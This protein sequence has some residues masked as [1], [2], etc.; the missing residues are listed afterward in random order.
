MV[1]QHLV[2]LGATCR[3]THI[4]RDLIQVGLCDQLRV[5][6]LQLLRDVHLADEG[7]HSDTCSRPGLEPRLFWDVLMME[8]LEGLVLE[9]WQVV[10]VGGVLL[11]VTGL[12]LEGVLGVAEEVGEGTGALGLISHLTNIILF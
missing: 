2:A 5:G 9:R 4:L 8:L 7:A 11:V 12:V 10:G 6:L 3:L 1:E